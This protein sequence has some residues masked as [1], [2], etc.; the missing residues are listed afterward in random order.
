[1]HRAFR[2]VKRNRGAAGV[3][4]VSIAMFAANLDDNLGA[5]MHDMKRGGFLPQ[6]LRRAYIPKNP[7][8]MR[9]LGIPSVRDHVAQ[10][11]CR[12]LLE[13]IFTPTFHDCSFGFIKGRHKADSSHPC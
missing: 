4:K 8:Q 7:K 10:D 12:Q 1:M 11:V 9:P 13:P 5:L 3:D 2:N 6:P